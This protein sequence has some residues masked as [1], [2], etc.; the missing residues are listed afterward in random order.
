MAH[1]AHVLNWNDCEWTH[2]REKVKFVTY[3]GAQSMTT[4][5]GLVTP[6][7]T[8]G[9]HAHEYEQL[10]FILQGTCDF[11]VD[12]VP[13]R[14]TAGCVMAVPPNLEH[15][16]QAIGDEDV[17]NLDVFSPK[18]PDKQDDESDRVGAENYSKRDYRLE[19]SLAATE[20]EKANFELFK[21]FTPSKIK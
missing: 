14:M 18:R 12:G 6:G 21:N 11:Y 19:S 4:T 8:V 10:V 20:E 16:I 9:P 7:H 5:L 2:S 1:K 13:N 3:Q 17:L 15:Y